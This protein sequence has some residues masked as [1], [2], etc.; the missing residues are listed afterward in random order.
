M[1][2]YGLPPYLR[3]L[4]ELMEELAGA[5]G[6]AAAAVRAKRMQTVRSAKGAALAPGPDT[7]L[8]IKLVRAVRGELTR[9]GDKTALAR[10]L[11]VSR[12]RLHLLIVAETACAD[13][14]RTLLLLS[15]LA[16]R[17]TPD[18]APLDQAGS[19]SPPPALQK[20]KPAPSKR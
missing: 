5:A 3:P 11:G 4:A 20:K 13:A 14:E 6:E 15:W 8:W 18:E 2:S 17:R 10:F 12:Q 7:P 1:K 19:Q 16:A 9:R